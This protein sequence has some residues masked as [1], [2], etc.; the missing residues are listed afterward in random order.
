MTNSETGAITGHH[1][2]DEC[3][4]H[5]DHMARSGSAIEAGSGRKA[6]CVGDVL[7]VPSSSRT[8]GIKLL[9]LVGQCDKL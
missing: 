5:P 7:R 4:G 8:E 9:T 3:K 6:D 1:G 2:V